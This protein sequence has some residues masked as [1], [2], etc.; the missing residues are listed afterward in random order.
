MQ[1]DKKRMTLYAVTDRKWTTEHTLAEQVEQALQG[2]A[3][4]IQLR[5]KKLS[6]NEFLEEARVIKN[7]CARYQ[8]PLIINDNV[9]IAMT[10][11]ADGVHLGQNDLSIK[12]ARKR[13]GE[14]KI[15]GATAR[16]KEQA[17]RAER[18]G[19]DYIGSGAV[20]GTSTKQDAK[21]MSIETLKEICEAVSIPVVAIGGIDR[22]NI[23]N[24]KGS[25]IAGTAIVSGIF[26]KKDVKTEVKLLREELEA[27]L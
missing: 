20:F 6:F 1:V 25:K 18:E 22:S 24:L 7:L 9:D 23:R 11:N 21:T 19:A 2:G 8:V 3:T 12:E 26:S 13:V 4:L 14:G 15:I 17:I 16:T 27:I 5:E 10:V